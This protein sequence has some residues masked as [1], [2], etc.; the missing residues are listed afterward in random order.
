MSANENLIISKDF[1]TKIKK[2]IYAIERDKALK[3][4][5]DPTEKLSRNWWGENPPQIKMIK[6]I[7]NNPGTETQAMSKH[8]R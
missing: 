7:D 2:P 4:K 1:D 6:T 5:K 3:L 8:F